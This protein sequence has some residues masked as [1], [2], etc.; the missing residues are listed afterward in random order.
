MENLLN[1]VR[2]FSVHFQGYGD[3]IKVPLFK[4]L[5]VRNHLTI[6]ILK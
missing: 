1:N 5:A 6:D 2:T 4:I 3:H